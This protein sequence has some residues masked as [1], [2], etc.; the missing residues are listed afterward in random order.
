MQMLHRLGALHWNFPIN[1][2]EFALQLAWV[3]AARFHTLSWLHIKL[4]VLEW[5]PMLYKVLHILLASLMHHKKSFWSRKKGCIFDQVPALCAPQSK[6]ALWTI[7]VLFQGSY[8]QNCVNLTSF[9]EEFLHVRNTVLPAALLAS[10]PGRREAI[11]KSA[12]GQS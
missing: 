3:T 5:E 9:P 12:W 7:Y 10:H 4:Q 1:S 2:G 8:S 11:L 6:V